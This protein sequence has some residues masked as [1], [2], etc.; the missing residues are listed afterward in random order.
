MEIAHA[1]MWCSGGFRVYPFRYFANFYTLA[2]CAKV[3]AV[4]VAF[5]KAVHYYALDTS[6]PYPL[7][8]A[9][10]IWGDLFADQ[11]LCAIN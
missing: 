6:M 9:S 11:P 5:E 7:G 1:N 3:M 10:A 2:P 4:V 8:D